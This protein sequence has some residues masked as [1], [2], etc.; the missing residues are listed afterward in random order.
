M[1][2][3]IELTPLQAREL[4][5]QTYE[6]NIEIYK[7]IL[8]TLDGDWDADLA[9]LKS[10]EGQEAARQC[11]MDRLERLAVLQ[12]FD[13]VTNLLKTEI[14]ERAKASAILAVIKG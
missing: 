5:V 14:V 11:P 3:D 13:Q 10:I 9:H 1:T 7:A 6:A 2:E 4:E 8:A 12:Q